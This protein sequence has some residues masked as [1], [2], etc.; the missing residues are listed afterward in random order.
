MNDRS[1]TLY[2]KD[3]KPII[4]VGLTEDGYE[5]YKSGEKLNLDWIEWMIDITFINLTKF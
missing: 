2:D 5:K 4:Q 3:K 1:I